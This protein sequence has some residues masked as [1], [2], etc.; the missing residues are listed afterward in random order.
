MVHD[1]VLNVSYIG[2]IVSSYN[3]RIPIRCQALHVSARS[4]VIP[5]VKVPGHQLV[6]RPSRLQTRIPRMDVIE[7]DSMV[8]RHNSAKSPPLACP[9]QRYLRPSTSFSHS[10]SLGPTIAASLF[11]RADFVLEQPLVTNAYSN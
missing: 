7:G 8:N 3:N 2:A 6:P 11:C 9:M 4:I 5:S 1:V 10:D